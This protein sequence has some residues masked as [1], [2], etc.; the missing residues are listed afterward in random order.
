MTNESK[1]APL[2]EAQRKA[3]EQQEHAANLQGNYPRA[4]PFVEEPEIIINGVTLTEG[5]AAS[6]RVACTNYHMQCSDAIEAQRIGKIALG[7]KVRLAEV[8]GVILRGKPVDNPLG[9]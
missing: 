2:A 7:Y 3:Q 1:F 8:M 9:K 5:Q 6:V 4:K